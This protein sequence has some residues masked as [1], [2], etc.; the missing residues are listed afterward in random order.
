MTQSIDSLSKRK[1]MAYS[2]AAG[3]GA[4][5][6]G[7]GADAAIQE[8]HS[9]SNTTFAHSGLASNGDDFTVDLDING[10]TTNDTRLGVF[11]NSIGMT[12]FPGNAVLADSTAG[13]LSYYVVGFQNGDS[14]SAA[15]DA[16]GGGVNLAFVTPYVPLY[17]GYRYQIFHTKSGDWI[18]VQFDISGNTHFGAI[19]I[20]EFA[21]LGSLDQTGDNDPNGVGDF[22]SDPVRVTLGVMIWEDQANTALNIPEPAS[23]GLL[24]IG[25]GAIGLRRRAS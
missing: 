11:L 16:A 23:L 12:G 7:Q 15:N 20:K 9:L 10:D 22:S 21:G 5:A 3:M 4:F 13:A 2:A 25:A 1:L 19:E 24:A 8:N 18:G 17:G 14:V 6:F